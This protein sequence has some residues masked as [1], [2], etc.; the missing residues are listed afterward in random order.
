MAPTT[1]FL[2]RDRT[3]DRQG[4][5]N[6]PRA[7]SPLQLVKSVHDG[8]EYW[9]LTDLLGLFHEQ[10]GLGP[11]GSNKTQRSPSPD[12]CLWKMVPACLS[13]RTEDTGQ[14]YS[15]VHGMNLGS[16]A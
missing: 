10:S 11:Y 9:A 13:Y 12:C 8:T 5:P 14:Q 1:S 3:V 15:N 7:L 16:I 6:W 2:F 4:S